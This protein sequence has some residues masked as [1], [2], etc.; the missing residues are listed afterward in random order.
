MIE[1]ESKSDYSVLIKDMKDVKTF[2]ICEYS[3]IFINYI[4]LREHRITKA[5]SKNLAF[6]LDSILKKS[7]MFCKIIDFDLSKIITASEHQELSCKDYGINFYLPPEISEYGICYQK[8]DIWCYGIMF[9][10]FASGQDSNIIY[11]FTRRPMASAYDCVK[12]EMERYK[13][14]SYTLSLIAKLLKCC[15][16]IN[17]DDRI[18]A[19]GLLKL[20]EEKVDRSKRYILH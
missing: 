7:E 13:D 8:S 1:L 10:L 12:Y 15:V 20:L 2:D 17:V 5:S 4:G 16:V 19:K 18:N 11:N 9:F 14:Y 3:E 6:E